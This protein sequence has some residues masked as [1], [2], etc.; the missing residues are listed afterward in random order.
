MPTLHAGHLRSSQN[1]SPPTVKACDELYQAALSKIVEVL[2]S[3]CKIHRLPLALTWAPCHQQGKGGC[4]HSDET[5]A[6]CVSTVDSA[7][8]VS[9]LE[10]LGFHEACS[11]H[12][13][14]RGQGIVRTAFTT[15]KPCFAT[16]IT[17]FSKT[18]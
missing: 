17:A 3:V 6:C 11:E 14:F 8:L 13:L 16:E 5:Y 18:E 15:N 2:I 10:I 1:F 4:H 12:H 7:C 9:D